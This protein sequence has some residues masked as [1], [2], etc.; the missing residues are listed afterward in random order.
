MLPAN[1]IDPAAAARWL[2]RTPAAPPW[3]HAEVAR[4]MAARLPAIRL[5]VQRWAQ[6][7]PALGG[8][9]STVA[10][11]YPGAECVPVPPAPPAGSVQMVWAN[12]LAHFSAA[13]PTLLAAW[14]QALSEGGFLMFSCL[15]P[16]TLREL[17]ALYSELDWPPPAQRFIDMHDWGDALLAAGFSDP[18]V[19]MEML[20]LSFSTPQRL[21]EE[22]REIGRNLHPARFS[23]L[24]TPRWKNRLLT[25]MCTHMRGADGAFSLTFEI[26]YGHAVKTTSPA[27][28][29]NIPLHEMR[30]M[31][32]HRPPF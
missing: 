13:A 16:D 18:V 2:R 31:L 15:G 14:C 4:R 3:L 27:A 20:T 24:R 25:A 12:M 7:L 9:H 21:L 11:H 22:L 29:A 26:I 10:A 1:A 28:A 17:R 8:G 5:P 30:R 23:A 6:W 19:D 32:R